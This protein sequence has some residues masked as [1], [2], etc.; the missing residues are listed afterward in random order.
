[1]E[2][3]KTNRLWQ[4]IMKASPKEKEEIINKLSDE[5]IIKL[6]YY[7][8]PY[9]KPIY[10]PTSKFLEFS[11]MNLR[12]EY[13]KNLMMTSMVGFMYKMATEFE[14]EFPENLFSRNKYPSEKDSE[15]ATALSNRLNIM[16]INKR[17][18]VADTPAKI[19][20]AKAVA[21]QRKMEDTAYLK[22]APTFLYKDIFD[23]CISIC[24]DDYEINFAE[25]NLSEFAEL[26]TPIPTAKLQKCIYMHFDTAAKE[27]CKVE[28]IAYESIY[29]T[30]VSLSA[31]EIEEAR[32]ATKKELNIKTTLEEKQLRIQDYILDFL[33]YHFKFDPNNHIRCSYMPNYD[34]VIQ[35]KIRQNPEK[36]TVPSSTSSTFSSTCKVEGVEGVE[37]EK[38]EK[39]EETH[40]RPM[41]ITKNF[42]EFLV[43]PMDTFHSFN[44]YFESNYE[45]LRQATDDIY[46][47]TDFEVAVIARETFTDEKK[48]DEWELKYKN[49]FYIGILRI[50]FG[51]WVFIDPFSENRKRTTFDDKKTKL[52]T[53]ILKKKKEE[54]KLG[55]ELLKKKT[56]KLKGRVSNKPSELKSDVEELGVESYDENDL[57]IKVFDTKLNVTRSRRRA[58]AGM[59]TYSFGR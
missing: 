16:S 57:E 7:A 21:A 11:F 36:Y 37:K 41:I 33:D 3:E 28:N 58:T 50:P 29:P 43:P 2:D 6:R 23:K 49:D 26:E 52:I 45:C 9:R 31:E 12:R 44:N 13:M 42:Q 55:Q 35:E 59:N 8:N 1:M 38:E 20:R 15:F 53:E 27:L 30:A 4:L 48:A 17:V 39:E 32:I 18:R 47:P 5:D 25:I 24:Y 46:G 51:N 34:A 10:N 14:F 40:R 56:R 19:L 22:V 54:E